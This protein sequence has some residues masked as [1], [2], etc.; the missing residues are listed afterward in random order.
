MNKEFH[1]KSSLKIYVFIPVSFILFL[2][3]YACSNIVQNPAPVIH[4]TRTDI[5]VGSRN[6][7]SVKKY[8][9]KTGNYIGDFVSAGSGGLNTTQDLLFMS[10]SVLLV[11]GI[12]NSTIKKYNGVNGA[13]IGDFTTGYSLANPTKMSIGRDGLIYVSQWGASQ[14]KIARFNISGSFVDE[15]TSVGV[16][17]G[18]GHAWDSTGNFYAASYGN[19]NNG[20][21]YKFNSSGTLLS[22]FIPTGNVQGPSNLWFNSAGDLFVADWTLGKVQHFNSQ[23]QFIGTYISGMQNIEGFAFLPDKSLLL[24]DWTRNV[25][26][27]FDSLGTPL[28]TFITTGALSSPNSIAVRI[29]NIN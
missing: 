9:G 8:D 7:S 5:Y 29:T 2:F 24:S 15:F 23:G 3:L 18:L 17:S 27:K 10:D 28:G 12:N 14:N 20:K 21:I 16:T 19:G 25:I 13:Y 1:Y 22:T 26:N 11:T 4:Q 6:T